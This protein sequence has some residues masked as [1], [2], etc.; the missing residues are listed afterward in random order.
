MQNILL[1]GVLIFLAF[2][3]YSGYRRGF[4]KIALSLAAVIVTLIIVSL[5]SPYVSSFLKEN[6]PLY[7]KIQSE[8]Q[9][10]IQEKIES[11]ADAQIADAAGQQDAIGGL[12]IPK[13][14]RDSLIENN[15]AEV[16]DKLGVTSFSAYASDYLSMMLLN[17]IAFMITFV[18]VSIVIR[19]IIHVIDLISRLPV[20]NGINKTAGIAAGL[21]E[22]IIILWIA[23]LFLTAISGTELGQSVFKMIN[24]S[25]ILSFIYNNNYLIRMITGLLGTAA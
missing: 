6:T 21:V 17:S 9:D 3:A 15:K 25:K 20:I 23:C 24:D 10:Y 1:I 2:F 19:L 11:N 13:A 7:T 22:G 14:L 12:P 18:A 4:I 8:M 16:Y 5:L